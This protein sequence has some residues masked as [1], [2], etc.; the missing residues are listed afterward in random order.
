MFI[1]WCRQKIRRVMLSL[2]DKRLRL[3]NEMLSGIKVVKLFAW[4]K[5]YFDRIMAVRN[6]ELWYL[7]WELAIFGFQLW[8]VVVI[9][10][11]A[12]A[13]PMAMTSFDD[14][15]SDAASDATMGM[16]YAGLRF[17]LLRMGVSVTAFSN[18]NLVL[19]RMLNFCTG[20]GKPSAAKQR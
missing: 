14:E 9:P 12:T 7:I 11:I 10:T 20:K 15:D 18:L 3:C 4:E 5:P 8:C 19:N 2:V 16:L 1:T 6:E 17:P 13:L